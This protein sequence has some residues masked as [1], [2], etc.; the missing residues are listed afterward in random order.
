MTLIIGKN[1]KIQYKFYVDMECV[2]FNIYIMKIS[3]KQ[4]T[5]IIELAKTKKHSDISI[6]FG[7][8]K[9][10]IGRILRDN[11][12]I[13]KR[14]R[15]NESKLEFNINYFDDIDTEEKSYWLGFISADGCLKS[16]KVRLV[17]KDEEVIIKFKN[18]ISSNHKIIKSITKDKRSGKNHTL[19]II[20]IT[21]YTFTKKLEKYINID[22]SNSFSFP[23]IKKNLYPYFISGLFDGDGSFSISNGKIRA[24][25]ISTYECLNEIQ[26][27]LMKKG[28]EK[29][30]ILE[31]YSTYRFYLYKDAFNFLNYIYDDN[32]SYLYLSRKYLKFKQYKDEIYKK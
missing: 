2:F 17:S 25:L 30:K 21:N 11:N 15:I 14:N 26:N 8:H 29:T 20:S 23:K 16:N 31:H 24:S 32:F 10:S 1:G 12:I 28:I 19:F 7:V 4:T 22:K 18:A 9:S 5:E 13:S 3:K 27:I 6:L